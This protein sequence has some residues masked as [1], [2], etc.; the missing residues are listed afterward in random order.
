ML[1]PSKQLLQHA[2]RN[3][4]AVGAFNISNLE[5]LQAVIAAARPQK[6]P[7]MI[8]TT[9]SAIAYA[10]AAYLK[11]IVDV[12]AQ[13]PMR[14]A[15][16][17]DHG[18]DIDLLK[19]CIGIGWTSVMFDGS[20]LPYAENVKK[21][22]QVVRYAHAKG[23]SVEGELGAIPGIE[24]RVH[25]NDKQAFFTDPIQAQ[26]FAKKTG[27]DALAISVGTAHGPYKFSHESILD[28][29][30][31]KKVKELVRVPLVLHGA[32]GIPQGLVAEVHAHCDS[33]GDC[34]RLAG[35][36]GVSD[37]AIKRAIHCGISKIDIDSDL[38]IAFLAGIRRVLLHDKDAY[39]PR[40]FLTEAK[41]EVEDIVRRKIKLFS[42]K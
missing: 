38:R 11:A 25:V 27:V 40:I 42:M 29:A 34:T 23:V 6:T 10:G 30:R 18:K 1:V 26:D 33:L 4:Y 31:I 35:A 5:T 9:E 8:A 7:V 37:S 41:K 20:L 13:E 15:L 17:L 36:R 22:A 19:Q 21:T 3:G 12:A 39:D 24:D 14:I 2:R 16:H 28:Y 32:S